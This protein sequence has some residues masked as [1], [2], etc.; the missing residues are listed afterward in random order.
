MGVGDSFAVDKLNFEMYLDDLNYQVLADIQKLD[1]VATRIS[2]E[3][4]TYT[5]FRK[6]DREEE[7]KLKEEKQAGK[8]QQP[9]KGAHF[10]V[11]LHPEKS[12]LVNGPRSSFVFQGLGQ[13]TN[14]ASNKSALMGYFKYHQPGVNDEKIK[15]YAEKALQ[16]WKKTI[17]PYH[18]YRTLYIRGVAK[19]VGYYLKE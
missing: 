19:L 17:V 14:N 13:L 1:Y 18:V 16:L 8:T 5:A 6:M 12:F 10:H 7:K 3:E 4:F 15:L 9:F 11:S 2:S